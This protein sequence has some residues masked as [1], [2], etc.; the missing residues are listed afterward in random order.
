MTAKRRNRGTSKRVSKFLLRL[1]L[2]M[3]PDREQES[4]F[5]MHS[6]EADLWFA[7]GCTFDDYEAPIDPT[8]RCGNVLSFNSKHRSGG[9]FAADR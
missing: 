8:C 5:N 9:T 7:M 3:L 1:N 4:N 2:G 6:P